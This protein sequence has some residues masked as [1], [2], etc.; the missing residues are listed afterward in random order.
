LFEDFVWRYLTSA[1]GK[2]SIAIAG[3]AILWGL[4][5]ETKVTLI[6]LFW[7]FTMFFLANLAA[8]KLPGGGFINNSSVVIVLFIPISVLCGIFLSNLI[9]AW[10]ALKF[11]YVR[12]ITNIVVIITG[13]LIAIFGAK[14][15][16]P[17]LNPGTILTRMA[18]LEAIAWVKENIPPSEPIV[19]NPFL[20]GYGYY[21]GSDGGYWILPEAGKITTPPPVLYAILPP[22][23]VKQVNDI[24]QSIIKI[25][26]NANE[27]WR[28]LTAN[29]LSYVFIGARGGVMSPNSMI[30]SGLFS[31]LYEN[32]GAYVFKVLP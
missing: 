8:L 2:Y 27:L 24:S 9:K 15:I 3:L 16:I 22:A 14:Q 31:T 30:E 17:I 1:F 13:V 12:L 7:I 6:Q 28:Y 23:E 10:R 32:N 25:G 4:L 21:A 26:G 29:E 18:D 19:I 20:W 5:H 11:R